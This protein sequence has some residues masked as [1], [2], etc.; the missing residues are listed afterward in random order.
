MASKPR[1]RLNGWVRI[2][3]VLSVAWALG[4]IGYQN[5]RTVTMAEDFAKSNLTRCFEDLHATVNPTSMEI[6]D[7][8]FREDINSVRTDPDRLVDL[9]A[10]ALAPIPIAW[11]LVL[12]L[13]WVVKWVRT[14]FQP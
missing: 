13:L 11:L 1:K 4:A 12:G 14:G 9:Y 10:F 6:C 5:H 7:K 8:K 3:I 2:G